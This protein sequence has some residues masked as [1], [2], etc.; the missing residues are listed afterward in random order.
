MKRNWI[1]ATMLLLFTNA[2]NALIIS[3]DGYGDVPAEGMEIT[4]TE[5]DAEEDFMTGKMRMGIQ[6]TLLCTAP[7]T[8]TIKRS[9]SGLEDEFCCA[10]TCKT[11]NAEQQ[12]VQSYSISGIATWF[13]HYTPAEG[14]GET[15]V[16]TFSDGT[17]SYDVTV[18]YL[19]HNT[20][21]ISQ[22]S[23]DA[24]NSAIHSITGV[25]F[26]QG[27]ERADLPAGVYIIGGKKEIII[28]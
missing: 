11:G 21:G 12:E 5:A 1:L 22:V 18:R 4:L 8:V 25:A 13:A 2:A 20:S 23:A 16:Y 26:P 24:A 17:E 15:I 6:G 7:L 14:S 3:I 9:A 28:R 10:G 27:T 19:Y